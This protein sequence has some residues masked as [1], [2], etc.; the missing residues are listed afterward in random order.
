VQAVEA[1][2]P[3]AVQAESMPFFGIAVFFAA[4]GEENAR[5]EDSN[6]NGDDDKRGSDA[7]RAR[8]LADSRI[9]QPI[10]SSQ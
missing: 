2:R 6:N 4:G 7:H 5:G 8:L 9:D 3:R 1:F 10:A